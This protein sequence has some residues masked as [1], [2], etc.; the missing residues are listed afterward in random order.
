MATVVNTITPNTRL[1]SKSRKR[2]DNPV[3]RNWH[4]LDRNALDGGFGHKQFT[5]IREGMK[6]MSMSRQ[7]D[8]IVVTVGTAAIQKGNSWF[9]SDGV[10]LATSNPLTP[11]YAILGKDA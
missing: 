8:E 5:S 6:V 11:H 9:A 1:K 4:H 7:G 3:E 10:E 2:I